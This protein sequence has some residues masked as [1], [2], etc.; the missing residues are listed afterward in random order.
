[1]RPTL[2]SDLA[3][4]TTNEQTQQTRLEKFFNKKL[5]RRGGYST[6]DYDDGATLF[7]ELKSRRIPHNKYPTAIIG[8]NKVET[9][10]KNPN[11]AYWF[12]YAYEDGIYGIKY[13][14]EVFDTFQH[15]DYSRGERADYHNRPQHCYFIP[16]DLLVK[17]D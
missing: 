3:Y 15:E 12:C 2:S 1:M 13:S 7:V 16:S 9:A 6:F 8:A 4:G 11:R 14:K 17:L 10:E 5:N